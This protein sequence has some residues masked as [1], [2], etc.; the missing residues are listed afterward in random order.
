ME[1]ANRR[2]R[3]RAQDCH[4]LHGEWNRTHLLAHGHTC[5]V[6]SSPIAG[7]TLWEGQP[8]PS[9]KTLLTLERS[10]LIRPA[11]GA[12][13][14]EYNFQHSLIQEVAYRSLLRQERRHMH[15]TVGRVLEKFFAGHAEEIAPELAE[16]FHQAEEM[17]RAYQYHL[18]AASHDL[19]VY[20]H[21][22]ALDHFDRAI[23]AGRE[24]AVDEDELLAVYLRRGRALELS[25]QHEVALENYTTMERQAAKLNRPSKELRARLQKAI[26]FCTGSPVADPE[27]GIQIARQ[28]LEQARHLEDTEAEARALWI[29]LLVYQL[30]LD[31]LGEAVETGQQ[32]LRLA[33]RLGIPL[34]QGMIANDLGSAYV[35]LGR[36]QE[37]ANILAEARRIMEQLDNMP[38]LANV[39]ANQMLQ[40]TVAGK[41][42]EALAF[43]D[44]GY[45]TSE[46]IGNLW[47]QACSLLYIDVAYAELGD[48]QKAIEAGS[49]C[50]RLGDAAGFAGPSVIANATQAWIRGHL[51][52]Q[53]EGLAHLQ[54]A[55]SE[56]LG[57]LL[58]IAGQLHSVGALLHL[59][60]EDRQSAKG[61][62]AN[63]ARYTGTE[64]A[65]LLHPS[66][67]FFNL[68]RA[69][70][71][72][73]SGNPDRVAQITKPTIEEM[74]E[75]NYQLLAPD[76][77]LVTG[78]GQNAAGRPQIAA[79]ALDEGIATADQIG[80]RRTLWQLLAARA[81][82]HEEQGE[83]NHA[84]QYRR[85]ARRIVRAIA[86]NVA[87]TGMAESFLN[88]A[89][90]RSLLSA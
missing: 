18:L 39:L 70:L 82:V 89:E 6:N 80:S 12:T 57:P 2:P 49:Q 38:M 23:A 62:L 31:H 63:A 75:F 45:E 13:P 76:Y 44:E 81:V 71:E 56:L 52:R 78:K 29:I 14:P 46:R 22:E 30:R 41:F 87:P 84:D 58:S 48:Y 17:A 79:R 16:H 11:L 33:R 1:L 4:Q 59:Q 67:L 55:P 21:Q 34:L 51:G 86:D 60:L 26:L 66:L 32:A 85:R 37:A 19:R 35:N 53:Q 73:A 47:G 27:V 90:V 74:K 83:P 50:L 43:S 20:A 69:S 9:Q 15:A 24:A 8:L 28:T 10:G 25:G 77:F 3:C 42:Q 68:A 88:Q 7:R 65:P 72:L 40:R 61:A 64:E 5:G 36:V 54:S